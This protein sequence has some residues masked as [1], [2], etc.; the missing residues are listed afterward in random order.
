M[1]AITKT[2]VRMSLFAGRQKVS[3]D[4]IDLALQEQHFGLEN[5]IEEMPEDQ[6]RQV[7]YHEAGHAI[8]Q[9]YLVPEDR[10]VRVTIKRRGVAL[11][12]VMHV[13]N[14]DVHAYPL[15]RQVRSIIVSL[16]GHV[17]TK[18]FLGEYWSGASGDFMQVRSR[19]AALAQFGYFGPP[20][21][22]PNTL[23]LTTEG[24]GKAP[25]ARFWREVEEQTERFL[26]EH[27]AEVDAVAKALLEKGDIGGQE[28]VEII[29]QAA[30]RNGHAELSDADLAALPAQIVD[31][32]TSPNGDGVAE[33]APESANKEQADSE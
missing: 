29:K 12:Y 5:P 25:Y 13:P 19:I 15:Q 18:L 10:I 31:G 2:A 32:V 1:S 22:D 27:A 21:S 8:A 4:D 24:D 11:G 17:A 3:Q 26:R 23:K 6:R 14:F 16:A 30:S 7:A 9:H 33:P 20:V 28:C